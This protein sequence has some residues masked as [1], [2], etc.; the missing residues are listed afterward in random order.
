MDSR[1]RTTLH[2]FPLSILDGVLNVV[3]VHTTHRR[4][5]R[6]MRVVSSA[7][8]ASRVDTSGSHRASCCRLTGI[9]KRSVPPL[10]SNKIRIVSGERGMLLAPGLPSIPRN[11]N[12]VR[13]IAPLAAQ[14]QG[15]ERVIQT[16]PSKTIL[17]WHVTGGS[18]WRR[19]R[20]LLLPT[21]GAGSWRFDR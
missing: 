21:T 7:V 14:A 11:T 16:I 15:H 12:R 4:P 6:C 13:V 20:Q 2:S 3:L 18:E 10:H 8:A 17:S 1:S 9:N 5:S 19:H